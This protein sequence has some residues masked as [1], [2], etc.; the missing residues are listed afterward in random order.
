MRSEIKAVSAQV[1]NRQLEV[2][3][4]T[5]MQSQWPLSSLQF[6]RRID[7]RLTNFF[8]SEEELAEV[9]VWPS[10]EVI[11]FPRIDQA[12]QVAALMRGEVGNADWMRRLL[13]QPEATQNSLV[14]E[15]S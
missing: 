9:E 6:A 7:G 12:F 13:T 2:V 10:G 5:G 8:P 15:T 1:N 3:F 4:S 11:E 14:F